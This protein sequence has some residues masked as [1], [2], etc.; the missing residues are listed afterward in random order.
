M[1]IT[2]WVAAAACAVTLAACG[3]TPLEQGLIGAGAGAG[4]AVV[5]DGNPVTGAV[6]GGAA[7]VVYC[8]RYPSRC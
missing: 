1:Q 6:V 5:L 3:D 4:A 8:Q 7:N 2:K